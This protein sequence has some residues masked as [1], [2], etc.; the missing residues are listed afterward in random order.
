MSSVVAVSGAGFEGSMWLW[1]ADHDFSVEG[2][3]IDVFFE[4][5]L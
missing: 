2:A 1:A 4:E 3:V 5:L